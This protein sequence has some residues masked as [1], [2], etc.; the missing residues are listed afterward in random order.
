MNIS[1]ALLKEIA[2][3][4]AALTDI[5]PLKMIA[6]NEQSFKDATH[7]H[8]CETPFSADTV[9]VRDHCQ[10]T[11]AYRGAACQPCN[12]NF[13]QPTFVP[14][15]FHDLRS[16]DSHIICASFGIIQGGGGDVHCIKH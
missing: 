14:V 2:R 4:Q 15:V 1:Y 10:L 11:G 16:F 5:Q 3:I 9:R 7:C 6:E 13:K 8:I 12:I